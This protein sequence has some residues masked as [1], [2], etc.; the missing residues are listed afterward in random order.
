MKK[1]TKLALQQETLKQLNENVQFRNRPRNVT[2]APLC[3]TQF[4][5]C[6]ECNPPMAKLE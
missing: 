4:Q 5:S 3:N 1:P 2:Q 6:P